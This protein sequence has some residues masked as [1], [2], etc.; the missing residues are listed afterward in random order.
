MSRNS[1]ARYTWLS[2][3]AALLTIGLKTAAYQLTGSVGLLSDAIESLVNLAGAVVALAMLTVAARP[4]DVEHPYGHDKAEYFSSGVEGALIFIA[5]LSIGYAALTRLLHPQPIEQ[6]GLGLGVSVVASLINLAVARVLVRAGREAESIT[7]EADGKHLMTD[8][9]TSVGVVGAVGAVAITG[10]QGLDPLIAIVVAANI[11]WT[12][13]QLLRRSVLGLLDTALPAAEQQAITAILDM[14]AGQGARYHALRTRQA[15]S[16]RFV[17]VDVLIPGNWTVARSHRLLKE[18][19]NGIQ[20]A[21]PRVTVLSHA[22]PLEDPASFE[23]S[24]GGAIPQPLVQGKTINDT[25]EKGIETQET[26]S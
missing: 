18:I 13:F 23:D 5:A 10:I 20:A 12:G 4:P 22:E 17:S 3:G 25:V 14:Y 6:P 7:L 19:E 15:A 16:R 21:L 1:L 9:W 8:V 11:V 26:T 24:S 2:I